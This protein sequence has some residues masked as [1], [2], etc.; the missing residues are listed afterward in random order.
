[1]RSYTYVKCLTTICF[2]L[3]FS[4]QTKAQDK[5]T[6][7]ALELEQVKMLR[8]K[9]E[10]HPEKIELHRAFI[11]AFGKAGGTSTGISLDDQYKIWIGKHPQLYAIPYAIGEMYANQKNSKAIPFLLRANKLNPNN[12]DDAWNLLKGNAYFTDNLVTRQH[13][14][15]NAMQYDPKNAQYAF[16]Y[17]RSFEDTDAKRADSLYLDVARRFPDSEFGADALYILAELSATDE[18]K[19]AY[20]KQYQ[21]RNPDKKSYSYKDAMSNYFDLLL[22]IDPARAFEL[23]L[24][25]ALQDKLF[26]D[27]WHERINVASQFLQVQKLI[28]DGQPELALTLANKIALD[29]P[30]VNRHIRAKESLALLKARAADAASKTSLAYD[31]L[32]V[33]YSKVPTDR[34]HTALYM[35]GQ[36][37]GKDSN[38]VARQIWKLRSDQ[39]KKAKDFQLVNY[40]TTQKVSL[41]DYKGKVILVTY[42][43]PLCTPCRMEFPHFESVLKKADSTHVAYLGLNVQPTEDQLVLPFLKET[44]YSFTPLR[45]DPKREKGNLAAPG[46]PSNYLIDQQ[47]RIIFSNFRIDTTNERTLE[48]M[49][50]ETLASQE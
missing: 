40:L 4:Y 2:L 28:T 12:N 8:I 27:V 25:M 48:L 13:Y 20:F 36:K 9:V 15:Q 46:A 7:T 19:I 16:D 5:H 18:E 22:N 42:W 39:A 34:L 1:M 49:I 33:L 21:L 32:S 43:F 14:M 30:A 44:G 31:S 6:P 29:N 11:D 35:Y 10:A 24:E 41:A 50:K 26:Q 23:G 37:L 17:A 47:G 38:T 3:S 45:D